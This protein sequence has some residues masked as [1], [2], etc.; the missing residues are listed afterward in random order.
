MVKAAQKK[1]N[2]HTTQKNDFSLC[3][4][5]ASNQYE[6]NGF[7]V[8]LADAQDTVTADNY[9]GAQQLQLKPHQL[10]ETGPS[11]EDCIVAGHALVEGCNENESRPSPVLIE[12][13]EVDL[14]Q[15]CTEV[16]AHGGYEKVTDASMWSSISESIGFGQ[17]C[18]ASMKL[19]YAKYLKSLET[20]KV[21]LKNGENV[22]YWFAKSVE[23]SST[24]IPECDIIGSGSSIS[25]GSSVCYQGSNGEIPSKRRK[26]S[27]SK[28]DH[29]LYSSL[30]EY[31]LPISKGTDSL[32]GMV[33]WI[34]RLALNPGDP[35]KGQ[36]PRGSKQN[37]AWVEDCQTMVIK[38]RAVLWGRKELIYYGS[39]SGNTAKQR[40]PPAVYYK[41]LPKPNTRTL[42][43][44]RA[45]QTRAMKCGLHLSGDAM[46]VQA[47]RPSW[48]CPSQML[49][50]GSGQYI[51]QGLDLSS[52][53]VKSMSEALS[54]GYLLNNKATRKRIPIGTPFQAQIPL[55]TGKA[56]KER[57]EF[58]GVCVWP[59]PDTKTTA[60]DI[61]RVGR[62]RPLRCACVYPMSLECVR[63]HVAEER[64]KLNK[65]IGEAFNSWGFNDMGESVSARWTKKEELIFDL[66][67]KSNPL[68]MG[69]NFWD[70]L[71]AALPLKTMK[72]LVSY[73]FNV[74]VVRRRAIENR[75]MPDSIDSDDDE[76]ELS[77]S[78]TS[79]AFGRN[80]RVQCENLVKFLALRR[81]A[82]ATVSN[83]A[84]SCTPCPLEKI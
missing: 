29:A 65:E 51:E 25:P 50:V 76:R 16:M 22:D 23:E 43:K 54:I 60:S 33:E 15:L 56:Q 72:E 77:S 1:V 84:T 82:T 11:I 55:W 78:G 34:R 37:E 24:G 8:V 62:G 75:T 14:L 64:G 83:T 7:L 26:L 3:G 28:E 9:S 58:G 38:A 79:S 80:M 5:D 42:E 21:M 36:G 13:K 73:Y 31:S 40:I 69:K 4:A 45:N 67:V 41:E 2:H 47:V 44:L 70:E 39:L 66:T 27:Y 71:P 19:V 68:S 12:G 59:L 81:E 30:P 35:K 46:E 49:P 18:G 10:L 6:D 48:L 61:G 20:S 52:D 32:V 63:L 57:E 74:F 53:Y 17:N